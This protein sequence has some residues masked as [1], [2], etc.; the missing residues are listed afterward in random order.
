MIDGVT[1]KQNNY[2]VNVVARWRRARPAIDVKEAV[3][4]AK[5]YVANVFAQELVA[6]LGLDEAELGEAHGPGR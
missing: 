4:A 5:G 2:P 1:F 6:D 3:Q